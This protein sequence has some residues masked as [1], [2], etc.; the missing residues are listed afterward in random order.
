MDDFGIDLYAVDESA[1]THVEADETCD[2]TAILTKSKVEQRRLTQGVSG[3]V[4][5]HGREEAVKGLA[6]GPT[7]RTVPHTGYICHRCGL[8]GHF[9]QHC[10]T[11]GD[12]KYDLRRVSRYRVDFEDLNRSLAVPPRTNDVVLKEADALP[13][14][15]SCSLCQG[16]FVEAVMIP[17]CQYSFCEKCI[18]HYLQKESPCPQCGS[19]KSK[20]CDLLPNVALRQAIDRFRSSQPDIDAPKEATNVESSVKTAK[21]GI[22]SPTQLHVSS[23]IKDVSSVVVVDNQPELPAADDSV[24]ESAIGSREKVLHG[25]NKPIAV[26]GETS[27]LGRKKKKLSIRP[28]CISETLSEH[29]IGKSRK[30]NKF[31]YTCGAPDHIARNCTTTGDNS[32]CFATPGMF[33]PFG[34]LARAINPFGQEMFWPGPVAYGASPPLPVG[35]YGP[36][37]YG[38]SAL[39]L[40]HYG[41]SPFTP[42]Y[43]NPQLHGFLDAVPHEVASRDR[44]LSREEFM[45]LQEIER[46]RRLT[47]ELKR[48][49]VSEDRSLSMIGSGQS[50]SSG[51]EGSLH[52][53]RPSL[54]KSH[55]TFRRYDVDSSFL[56][57]TGS[58][59]IKRKLGKRHT[60]EVFDEEVSSQKCTDESEY[61]AFDDSRGQKRRY[62][63]DVKPVVSTV[64]RVGKMYECYS[65]SD[66]EDCQDGK[67]HMS[68]EGQSKVGR[69]TSTGR[70]GPAFEK[71]EKK[72][73]V[74]HDG[75]RVSEAGAVEMLRSSRHKSKKSL[76]EGMKESVSHQMNHISIE[77]EDRHA[78]HGFVDDDR[79]ASEVLKKSSTRKHHDHSQIC[80]LNDISEEETKKKRKKRKRRRHKAD[81]VTVGTSFMEISHKI[82]DKRHKSH[83]ISSVMI[84]ETSVEGTP[85]IDDVECGRWKMDDGLGE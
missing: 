24:C 17:C 73:Y 35:H 63:Q 21:K 14:E 38:S 39:P 13:P 2:S 54:S 27:S 43:P 79:N 7:Y 53:Q 36:V 19:G 65:D 42:M 31:C 20:D 57:E 81:T 61:S 69:S 49:E 33:P 60:S 26:V 83:H 84:D 56:R 41:V 78:H 71:R 75:T 32:R 16:I 12:P 5:E 62:H 64:K 74:K 25:R 76:L 50:V 37:P 40:G 44:P 70:L 23:G 3:V 80:T 46:R 11:N 9:I 66:E 45:E 52:V 82:L 77:A 59:K 30:A 85:A 48:R 15:L 67:L 55:G 72:S 47:K 58:T 1:L 34:P 68:R 22:S 10:P 28:M 8:P 4:H 18:R 51:S 6:E 29:M